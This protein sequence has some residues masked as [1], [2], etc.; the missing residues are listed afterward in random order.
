MAPDR[1]M[2]PHY[3][4]HRSRL[5]RRLIDA[6]A[7]NLPDYELLEVLLF[8]SDAR[9]DVKPIAKALIERF[10][11]LAAVLSAHSDALFAAGLNI[12]A[13]A[14]LE[15]VREVAL[16]MTR[17]ESRQQPAINSWDK[18]ID[19]CSAE[20]TY[21]KVEKF[22]ILFLDRK[23]LLIKHERQEKAA[24]HVRDM[25]KRAL[26]IGA[27]ALILVHNHLTGGSTPSKIDI[28]V[29]RQIK[30]AMTPLG[31]VLHDYVVINRNC[32]VS[33]RDLKLI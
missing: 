10:G 16:R 1:H 31:V 13:V 6:G 19:Y 23:N 18:L 32:Y 33:L 8:V 15:L 29:V 4:G 21:N 25:V 26:D 22:H 3:H 24:V 14:A 9:R 7:E 30:E 20:V 12:A 5:R 11:S 27:A 2:V 17:A 28:A